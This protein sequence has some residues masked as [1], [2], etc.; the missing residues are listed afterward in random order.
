MFKPYDRLVAKVY[1]RFLEETERAGLADR[2]ERL[3]A[4]ARGRVLE[5]GAGTGLNLAHYGPRVEALTLTEPSEAMAAQLKRRAAELGTTAEIVIAPAHRLPFGD[6]SFDTVLVTLALCTV[7]DPEASLAEIRR[8]LAPSGQLLLIEHVRSDDP[9]RAKWQDRLERPWRVVGNG[10]R[11]NRDTES[12]VTA[13]GF[14][15]SDIEH[16]SMRKSMPIV[17]PLI[18][19]RAVIHGEGA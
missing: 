10:C 9:A 16:G 4:Q 6:D 19:G 1:D 5:I 3:A 15:F 18:Q 8:V 17:R 14:H 13:A 2:R 11:C 7:D 12:L